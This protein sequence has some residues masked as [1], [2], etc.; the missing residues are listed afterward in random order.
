LTQRDA[1]LDAPVTMFCV[2]T[3]LSRSGRVQRSRPACQALVAK[4]SLRRHMVIKT[5]RLWVLPLCLLLSA[6]A[7][8]EVKIAVLNVQRAVAESAEA[9]AELTKI[10]EHLNTSQSEIQRLNTE[11]IELQERLMRDA[12]VMSDADARRL[13][14]QLQDMQAD[15]QFR[16]NRLQQDVNDR[17]QEV[18]EMMMPKIDAVLNDMIEEEGYD[19]ILHR[20]NILYVSRAHDITQRV[21]EKLNARR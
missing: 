2:K 12:D 1:P 14:R 4:L 8:A 11:M 13:Q 16:V 7:Y 10:Q 9:Q 19:L 20:Q 6:G 17:Q 21:T 18:L 15:I 3:L 5:L